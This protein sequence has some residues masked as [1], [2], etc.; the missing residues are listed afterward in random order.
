MRQTVSINLCCY[1][2]EKYLEETLKSIFNQTYRNWELVVINDG[3]KDST[4][5]IIEKYIDEGWPIIYHYQNN[6]GLGRA[7]NK[8]IELSSGMFIAI[9]DHDD[10]WHPEKL[11][12]Q[13]LLFSERPLLGLTYTNANLLN[14]TGHLRLNPDSVSMYRGWV[15][16]Q[17]LLSDFVICSTIV[18]P[19]AILDEVGWF[20]PHFIQV[21]EYDLMIR[22]AER[23]EFDYIE[24]PL[25]T[26]RIHIQNSSWDGRRAQEELIILMHRVLLRMPH[27]RRELGQIVTRL[28]LSGLSCTLGCAFLMQGR[29]MDAYRW[30]GG[31]RKIL[32]DLP[33]V[34]GLYLLSLFPQGVVV[35]IIGKWRVARKRLILG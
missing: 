30:Y 11:E 22:V 27:L 13:M 10:L 35:N 33:R 21:E 16:P 17:L 9:I 19:R 4:E 8:A 6:A 12:K 26:W 7:R 2:S 31:I 25:A 32:R 15:L 3:S 20:D 28:K 5:R 24:E 14:L 1:N 23:Y 34:M 18:L 29:F